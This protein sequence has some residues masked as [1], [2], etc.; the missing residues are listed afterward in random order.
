MI[1]SSSLNIESDI[2]L[3]QVEMIKED[4]YSKLGV[5]IFALVK[6]SMKHNITTEE[7]FEGL[8]TQIRK[9]S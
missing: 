5:L 4:R 3:D 8:M 9:P 7:V 2:I 1:D 6:F